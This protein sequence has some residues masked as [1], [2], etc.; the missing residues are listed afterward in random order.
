MLQLIS[1]ISPQGRDYVSTQMEQG[2]VEVLYS[3]STKENTGYF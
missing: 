3:I 1:K 2:N